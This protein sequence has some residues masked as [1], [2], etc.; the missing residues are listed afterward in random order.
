MSTPDPTPADSRIDHGDFE[1][2]SPPWPTHLVWTKK[3]E[4]N[5][6]KW[7]ELGCGYPIRDD[8]GLKLIIDTLPELKD[9]KYEF[10]VLPNHQKDLE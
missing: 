4:G 3:T 5:E 10:L 7:I 2:S 1:P 6:A 8:G 9:G